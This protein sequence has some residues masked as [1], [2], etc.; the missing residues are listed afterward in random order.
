MAEWDRTQEMK[1]RLKGKIDRGYYGGRHII[2]RDSDIDGGVYLGK[3]QREAIVVDSEKHPRLRELYET[4]K[5]KMTGN[6]CEGRIS[7][8][9]GDNFEDFSEARYHEAYYYI[10][11]NSVLK[12]VYDTVDEAMPNRDKEAVEEILDEHGVEKDGKISLDIFIG[13]GVGVCRHLALTCAALLE[14]FK[15]DGVIKGKPGV[16]RNSNGSNGH[17]WCRYTNPDGEIFIL[18]VGRYMGKLSD[19][20]EKRWFYERPEDS[21]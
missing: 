5:D 11:E 16:D 15:K 8:V 18:D 9:V 21:Q 20:S 13:R 10:T 12:A 6:R 3:N 1:Q 17:A 7:Q 14:L 4:S 19:A 2:H